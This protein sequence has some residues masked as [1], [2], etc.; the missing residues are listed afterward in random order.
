MEMGKECVFFVK[1]DDK[2][3]RW[4]GQAAIPGS[5]FKSLLPQLLP[6]SSAFLKG[7]S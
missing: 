6:G 2:R 4:E 5:G 7:E 1:K 3:W